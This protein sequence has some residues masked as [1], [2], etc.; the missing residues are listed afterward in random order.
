M[1]DTRYTLRYTL[2][3]HLAGVLYYSSCPYF[4]LLT[5]A[6]VTHLVK[7]KEQNDILQ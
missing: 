1:L 2:T 3:L 6:V 7:H 4:P 5:D